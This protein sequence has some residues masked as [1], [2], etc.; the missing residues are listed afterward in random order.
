MFKTSSSVAAGFMASR[1]LFYFFDCF[2]VR[3]EQK[4]VGAQDQRNGA[5]NMG[6]QEYLSLLCEYSQ[7]N[8]GEQGHL[9][10]DC[11]QCN[12]GEQGHLLCD[13]NQCNT[14]EQATNF[15]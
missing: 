4:T 7:C 15:S 6:E 9:L 2:L 3:R 1:S 8:T 14:G 5:C 11:S 12:T 10:G 13:C